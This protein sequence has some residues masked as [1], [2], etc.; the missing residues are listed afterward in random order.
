M[1]SVPC[2]VSVLREATQTGA[3]A[4]SWSAGRRPRGRGDAGVT[5]PTRDMKKLN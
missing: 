4:G 2:H 1:Q 5:K 3:A